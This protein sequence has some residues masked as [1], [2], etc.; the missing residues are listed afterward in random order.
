MAEPEPDDVISILT[1]WEVLLSA[2]VRLNKITE[3][4]QE[5]MINLVVD[6][7]WD[8]ER[9]GYTLGRAYRGRQPHGG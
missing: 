9:K 6:E 4:E 5:A 1:P 3:D 7:I 2:W 8:H